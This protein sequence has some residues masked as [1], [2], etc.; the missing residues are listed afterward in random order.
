[1]QTVRGCHAA[2]LTES[3]CIYV[4]GGMN[5]H[6]KVFRRCEK[7]SITYGKW[8]PI[9][10]MIKARKNHSACTFGDFIYVIGGETNNYGAR[11]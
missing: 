4:L 6:E 1:M 11:I 7:Y 10:N 8:S 9:T 5:F 3:N 2:I